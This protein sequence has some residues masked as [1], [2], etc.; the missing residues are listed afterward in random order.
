MGDKGKMQR[1]FEA[2]KA[3]APDPEVFEEDSILGFG[4]PF[5]NLPF[6]ELK[7]VSPSDSHYLARYYENAF[8]CLIQVRKDIREAMKIPCSKEH[9][10]FLNFEYRMV[11]AELVDAFKTYLWYN[12]RLKQLLRQ[13]K[14]LERSRRTH[15]T[16]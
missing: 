9:R 11:Q 3:I 8:D 1:R 6:G 5:K 13:A 14:T 12:K 16:R 10:A 2:F 15:A 4:K 7:E